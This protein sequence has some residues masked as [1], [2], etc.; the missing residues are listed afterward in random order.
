MEN[1][2]IWYQLIVYH[3]IVIP[4]QTNANFIWKPSQKIWSGLSFLNWLISALIL[5]QQFQYI[6]WLIVKYY[7]FFRISSSDTRFTRW[8]INLTSHKLDL[9][10]LTHPIIKPTDLTHPI[11]LFHLAWLKFLKLSAVTLTKKVAPNRPRTTDFLVYLSTH[12]ICVSEQ[13]K[14]QSKINWTAPRVSGI[15]NVH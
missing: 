2:Q 12:A 7:N 1:Y 4:S 10:D 6:M 13:Q 11:Y 5:L 9:T 3:S 15:H 8:L 14:L